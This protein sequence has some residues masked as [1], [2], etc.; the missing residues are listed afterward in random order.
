[1]EEPVANLG[2]STR[3]LNGILA[4]RYPRWSNR[5]PIINVGDLLRHSR[6]DLLEAK[7]LGRVSLHEIEARLK[8]RGLC[9]RHESPCGRRTTAQP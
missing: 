1:M 7:G 6:Y 3:A 8:D 2:L 5:Y 9:L 4:C